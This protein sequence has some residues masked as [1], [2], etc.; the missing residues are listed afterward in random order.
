MNRF[1]LL[2]CLLVLCLPGLSRAVPKDAVNPAAPEWPENWRVHAVFSSVEGGTLRWADGFTLP[3]KGTV[4]DIALEHP[5]G[6]APVLRVWSD[7]KLVRG[8]EEVPALGSAPAAD[9]PNTKTDL[10]ANFT[11]Y[12][13][14]STKGGGTLFSKCAPADKWSPDAKALFIRGGRLVYD[15]GWLGAMSGGPA[16]NDGSPHTVI[17][18]VTDGLAALWLDGKQV[19][20]KAG[21][22]RPDAAGHILKT[23]R[24]APDFAGA[25]AGQLE[26]VRLWQRALSAAEIASLFKEGTKGANTPDF[27]WSPAVKSGHPV[28]APAAGAALR[29]AW[30]QPL[31]RADHGEIVRGWNDKTLA[32]GK[33]IYSQLCIVCHGTKEQAGS[34][35]T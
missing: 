14:F 13:R 12:S 32:E 21:H 6:S 27:E 11:A 5:E 19:A 9:F 4:H 8:P 29:E 3:L 28:L 22:T 33:A 15:I 17:L 26:D 1:P 10:G 30:V 18:T 34:L 7:G 23:G 25:F 2:L 24:A 20:K 35:P 16:V 31:E